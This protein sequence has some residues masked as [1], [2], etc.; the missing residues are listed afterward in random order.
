MVNL[1]F[2]AEDIFH[3]TKSVKVKEEAIMS[4][5]DNAMAQMLGVCRFQVL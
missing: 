4:F 2:A 5:R 3:I 1:T